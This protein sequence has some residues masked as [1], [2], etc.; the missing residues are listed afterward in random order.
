[1]GRDHYAVWLYNSIIDSVPL[2]RLGPGGSGS[3]TLPGMVT[4]YASI[5]ISG[6]PAGRIEPSGDSV[7][8]TANPLAAAPH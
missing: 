3:F 8:R 7:L 4:R 6:Q 5:D 2:G 1:M